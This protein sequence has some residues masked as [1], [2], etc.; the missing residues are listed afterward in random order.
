MDIVLVS[1]TDVTTVTAATR[2]DFNFI[3]KKVMGLLEE[4]NEV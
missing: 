4:R 1:T 2:S 3:I